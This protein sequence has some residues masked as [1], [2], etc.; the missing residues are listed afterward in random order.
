MLN[1]IAYLLDEGIK[2][3]IRCNYDSENV[4]GIMDFLEDIR[5]RFGICENLSI[6]FALLFQT[7]DTQDSVGT[8]EKVIDIIRYFRE[9]GM[10]SVVVL[11]RAYRMRVNFCMADS[12]GKHVVIDPEGFLYHCEHLPDN[13][14]FGNINDEVLVFTSDPRASMSVNSQCKQCCFLPYCTPFFRN[15]CP[16]WH[17]QCYEIKRAEMDF[18]LEQI[19]QNK[20]CNREAEI[21]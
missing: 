9:K 8:Q 2:V 17:R 19:I 18:L 4:N 5:S 6:Y 16:T 10:K 3:S 21:Q 12:G 11:D 15:G 20:I 13:A 14:A 7:R 1:S